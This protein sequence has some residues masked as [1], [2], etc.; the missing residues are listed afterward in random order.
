MSLSEI[1][2]QM[3]S[4]IVPV[5][6]VEAFLSECLE[7]ISGQT[8]RDFEAILVDDGSTDSSGKIC[9]DYCLKDNRFRVIHQPNAGLGPARNTGIEAS[10]GQYVMFVDSDDV[11]APNLVETLLNLLLSS[12]SDLAITGHVRTDE[13]GNPLDESQGAEDIQVISGSTAVS[14]C[15]FGDPYERIVFSVAWAKLYPRNVIQSLRA[16]S[17]YSGQDL[18]FNFKIYQRVSSVA[19]QDIREYYWRQRTSSITHVNNARQ[20]YWRFLSIADLDKVSDH[21]ERSIF[22]SLY[23]KKVYRVMATIRNHLNGTEYYDAF[24]KR[25]RQIRSCS[26]AEY[27]KDRNIEFKEKM[28]TSIFWPFPGVGRFIFR[29]SGN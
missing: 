20:Q 5:Y 26:R 4:I 29:L 2:S 24:M 19:F 9:E 10:T 3:I 7:S 15:F 17:Y 12:G 22:R 14:K 28:V 18:N 1:Q 27:L 21:D 11:I 8:F 25:C 13:Q 6:N 16:G 23:L